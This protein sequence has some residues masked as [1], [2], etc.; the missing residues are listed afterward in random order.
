[1]RAGIHAC[2][3]A[4]VLCVSPLHAAVIHV[5]G[6]DHDLLPDTPGQVIDVLVQGDGEVQ[7]LNFYVMVGNGMTDEVPNITGVAGEPGVD[8]IGSGTLFEGNNNEQQ[9][10]D[11][12]ADFR[13]FWGAGT[14]TSS[15][16]VTPGTSGRILAR[17]T[18]NTEGFFSGSFDLFLQ[19]IDY[20][21]SQYD[22]DFVGWGTDPDLDPEWQNHF[23]TIDD[24]TLNIVPEPSSLLLMFFGVAGLGVV[25]VM[26]RR[27]D[28]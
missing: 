13:G 16:T 25:T 17:V 27:R 15:G 19:N 11:Q 1:M 14:T 28:A 5:I 8:I 7:G 18:I 26:R 6:G 23:V 20:L 2:V 21:G 9:N 22:T 12:P 3:L 24:G 10:D 4:C